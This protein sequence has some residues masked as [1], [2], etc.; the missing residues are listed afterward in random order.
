MRTILKK[1]THGQIEFGI[2]YGAIALLAVCV[3]RFVPVLTVAPSC[4]FKGLTGLPCPTCGATRSVV[5]LAQGALSASLS[6]N[7]LVPL[8]FF[9][10]AIV[11]LYSL[12]TL[13][14]GI[15]RIGV[16]LSDREKNVVRFGTVALVLGNWC[17]LIFSR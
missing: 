15:P 4:V 10:A 8:C 9:I 13:I 11:F 17:Y 3:G 6:L 16:I 7:P 2:I 1:R 12:I 5:H 14:F